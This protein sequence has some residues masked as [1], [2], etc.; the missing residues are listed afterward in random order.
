MGKMNDKYIDMQ[1]EPT[2]LIADWKERIEESLEQYLETEAPYLMMEAPVTTGYDKNRRQELILS[3]T[4]RLFTNPE[5]SMEMGPLSVIWEMSTKAFDIPREISVIVDKT[6]QVYID[7]GTPGYVKFNFE[8]KG[9]KL[10]IVCWIHT[11]PMGNAYF[12]S[13]DWKTL[14]SWKTVMKSA[15]VLGNNEYW[16]YDIERD[17]AKTVKYGRLRTEEKKEEE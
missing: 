8:P 13:T 7:V 6:G 5:S 15:I 14:D 17:I 2:V 10:P 1:E 9:M 12:S 11:H 16:A 4:L 3:T